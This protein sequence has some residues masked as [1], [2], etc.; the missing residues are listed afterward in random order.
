MKRK[1]FFISC[2][3]S[4]F[5]L[6]NNLYSFFKIKESFNSKLIC[7][8][9]VI[10]KEYGYTKLSLKK[11][12]KNIVFIKS[13][14]KKNIISNLFYSSS[15]LFNYLKS[16]KPDICFILGDRIETINIA[17]TIK[18][19]NI[20]IA[21]LHGGES[22]EGVYDDYWRH[23]TSKLSNLHFV[24]NIIYKKNLIKM[25]E[26]KKFIHVVGGYG[27]ENIL[28]INKRYLN[29]NFFIEK[30]K[31][32]FN[33]INFLVTFH[34]NTFAPKTNVNHLK[35]ITSALIDIKDSNIFISIPG[36]DIGSEQILKY[37][38]SN[39][40]KTNN[41][42][43]TFRS[44]GYEKYLSLAKICDI[45]LGNSSSGIIEIPY[46]NK[47][48]INIGDRQNGRIKPNL[49]YDTDYSKL[50]IKKTVKKILKL[51]KSNQ[52]PSNNKVYGN[53]FSAKKT[54][55]IIEKLD[56]KKIKNKNF[57]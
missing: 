53:G 45:T 13:I 43:Y 3:R 55:N 51:I 54:Y 36:Y 20:P 37:L 33:K 49:V 10:S 46:L 15:N 26:D 23:S 38:K 2:A 28:K 27:I 9:S 32:K 1:F 8:G 17:I 57:F 18:L 4:D 6:I 50:S 34:S 16:E 11:I 25:G 22:T 52:L 41:R 29:K 30:N 48:V 47:P 21:H 19:L 40:I 56:F 39:K 24:S 5:D 31:F 35:N 44:I 7:C 14:L 12:D 42:I